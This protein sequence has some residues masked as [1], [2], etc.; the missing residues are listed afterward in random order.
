MGGI[1]HPRHTYNATQYGFNALI[2]VMQ[3]YPPLKSNSESKNYRPIGLHMTSIFR[4]INDCV[5]S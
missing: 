1:L 2:V 5:L 3:Q 4:I